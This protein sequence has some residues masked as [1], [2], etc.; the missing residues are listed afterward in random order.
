MIT[1]ETNITMMIHKMTEIDQQYYD[2]AMILFMNEIKRI[3][4]NTGIDLLCRRRYRRHHFHHSNDDN[5]KDNTK[6]NYWSNQN[7]T[8]E[9]K[10][11]RGGGGDDSTLLL[12]KT[13]TAKVQEQSWFVVGIIII[14]TNFGNQLF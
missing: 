4:N 8:Q 1:Q 10:I 7:K 6:K 5:D 2:Y 9:A 11:W 12:V 13:M 14:Q 3:Q